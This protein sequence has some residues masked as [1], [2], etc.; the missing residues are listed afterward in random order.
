MVRATWKQKEQ[1]SQMS[2]LCAKHGT[3]PEIKDGRDAA[4]S[5]ERGWQS[6]KEIIKRPGA[7]DGL[8]ERSRRYFRDKLEFE[9]KWQEGEIGSIWNFYQTKDERLT[10]EIG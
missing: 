8:L 7:I 6:I 9:E 4:L 10:K 5:L 2:I 1:E 3:S